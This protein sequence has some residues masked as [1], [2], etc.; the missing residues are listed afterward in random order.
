MAV[1]ELGLELATHPVPDV[2]HPPSATAMSVTRT[3]T[4][5]ATGEVTIVTIRDANVMITV[6]AASGTNSTTVA[7]GTVKI[8][9]CVATV[10][11]LGTLNEMRMTIQGVGGMMA[12]AMSG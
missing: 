8:F 2:K 11:A 10:T 6:A 1:T 4:E 5:L 7:T 9:I 3:A 12:N